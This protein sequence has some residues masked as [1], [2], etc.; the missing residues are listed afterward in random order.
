MSKWTTGSFRGGWVVCSLVGCRRRYFLIVYR[1]WS[2]WTSRLLSIFQDFRR[3]RWG[4]SHCKDW[5]NKP[6]V[7]LNI[8][9]QL[10]YCYWVNNIE[11]NKRI[12]RLIFIQWEMHSEVLHCCITF[13][14]RYMNY[15]DWLNVN[16]PGL[17]KIS[18]HVFEF[19]P[20]PSRTTMQIVHAML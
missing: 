12:F 13:P 16:S 20:R 6:I 18:I 5:A 17:P 7:R 9:Q 15:C 2:R 11:T 19:M 8:C 1:R 10:K 3:R 14:F 4:L